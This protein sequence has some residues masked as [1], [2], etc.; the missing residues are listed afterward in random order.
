[1]RYDKLVSIRTRFG[2]SSRVYRGSGA[3]SLP[4]SIVSQGD[5]REVR[6]SVTC[7]PMLLDHT[8]EG[9]SLSPVAGGRS[10]IAR[11]SSSTRRIG[12]SHRRPTPDIPTSGARGV[13]SRELLSVE[14]SDTRIRR[15]GSQIQHTGHLG[16]GLR[17][18]ESSHRVVRAQ[19]ASQTFVALS[20]PLVHPIRHEP[21]T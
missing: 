7:S 21:S 18:S 2:A 9:D 13:D 14:K 6:L 15:S 17:V 16:S 1:M 8:L 11:S 4:I 3:R 10:Q 5:E 20:E 19:V 12:I